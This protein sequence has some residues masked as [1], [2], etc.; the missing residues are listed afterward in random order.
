MLQQPNPVLHCCH[1]VY[2]TCNVSSAA[3]ELQRLHPTTALQVLR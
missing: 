1:H 2:W 3:E